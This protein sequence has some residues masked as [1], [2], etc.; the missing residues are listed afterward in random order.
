MA[1]LEC[2]FMD[3]TSSEPLRLVIRGIRRLQG[4]S[5]SNH[6]LPVTVNVLRTLK[7]QIRIRN[8]SLVEHRL[9]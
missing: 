2:G 5:T 1:H 7:L 8:F 4:D 6:R 3:P 9:L